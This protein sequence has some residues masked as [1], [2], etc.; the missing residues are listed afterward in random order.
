MRERCARL[1]ALLLCLLLTSLC[2]CAQP[3]PGEASSGEQ[4]SEAPAYSR[5]LSYTANVEK[6]ESVPGTALWDS[7]QQ[8]FNVTFELIPMAFN[9]RHDMVRLWVS[10]GNVPDLMWMDLDESMFAEY[11]NW[12]LHGMFSA[13]PSL[14]ELE[15]RWPN[16]AAIYNEDDFVGDELM[17][18]DGRQYAHPCR[19]ENPEYNY[20]SGMGWMYRR[21]WAKQL[22]LYQENDVYTWEEWVELNRAFVEQDPG[23]NGAGRTI[24]MGTEL[25]YFPSAMGVYQTSAEYGYGAYSPKDGQY[26]WTAAREET[27]QGLLIAK[28]LYD[29]GIIWQDNPLGQ[30]PDNV[31]ASG[32]MGSE[33]NQFTLAR[34]Y[35]VRKAI[36]E[37]FPDIDENEAG[38][39]A[40][41]IGP[42]G[43]IW[44][45]QSQCYYGAVLMAADIGQE[46][47]E[48]WLDM[49]DWMLT[50]EG[51]AFRAYGIEGKDWQY[52]ED[53]R[54]ECLWPES[55]V[56]SGVQVDPYPEGSR[57]F[58]LRYGGS[59]SQQEA[60][61]HAYPQQYIDD[62]DEY[63]RF[64]RDNG[65]MRTFDYGSSYLSA[66]HKN[67]VGNV[68]TQAMDKMTELITTATAEELPE[69]W[70]QWI[71]QMTPRIQ[72]VL[73]ELN[74]M[75][76]QVPQEAQPRLYIK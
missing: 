6:G 33:F 32:L 34:V 36:K 41:V 60:P 4:Q 11:A 13:Y 51:V 24:G 61:S 65:F 23:G 75:I 74:T 3:A 45:K 63:F 50:E 19:R 46:K 22:G 30:A 2:G 10:S 71:D 67:A 53:G 64:L 59:L 43:T 56:L 49:L 18:I 68:T 69:L 38:A 21:D 1:L 31:Y 28:Q 9:D 55:R 12:S 7:F 76:E 72:P 42:D 58:F 15:E 47:M 73:D 25:Y 26:V 37:N 27:L 52:G 14:E 40:K 66:E 35:A 29:E 44:C 48:R 8:R 20:M 70:Q 57:I 16:I 54:I 17:T 39:L 62:A 5:T